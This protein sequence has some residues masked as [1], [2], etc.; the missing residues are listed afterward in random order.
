MKRVQ[1]NVWCV[2]SRPAAIQGRSLRADLQKVTG[3]EDEM[4]VQINHNN[5][6]HFT[7]ETVRRGNSSCKKPTV[8]AVVVSGLAQ[9][10]QER[11]LRD[12]EAWQRTRPDT[13]QHSGW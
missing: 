4:L 2:F 3:E 5:P 10:S 13:T 11:S 6:K 8:F 12:P 9:Y 1:L 7:V